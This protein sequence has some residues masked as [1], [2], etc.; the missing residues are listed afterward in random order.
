[1]KNSMS[2]HP[3]DMANLLYYFSYA[4]YIRKAISSVCNLYNIG[5]YRLHIVLLAIYQKY[6]ES[7]FSFRLYRK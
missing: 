1:M 6:K 3:S 4:F 7:I 5:N 2:L